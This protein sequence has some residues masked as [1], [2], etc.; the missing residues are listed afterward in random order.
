MHVN[1]TGLK[2]EAYYFPYNIEKRLVNAVQLKSKTD[3]EDALLQIEDDLDAHNI[4]SL[5]VAKDIVMQLSTSVLRII[6][7]HGKDLGSFVNEEKLYSN[8]KDADSREMLLRHLR[9]I[10]VKTA[11]FLDKKDEDRNKKIIEQAAM[12]IKEK[13]SSDISIADIADKVFISPSHLSRTFKQYMGKT[14]NDYINYIRIEKSKELL[15][16]ASNSIE[17][18]AESVG[19]NS[20]QNFLRNFKL[21]EGITPTE[22]KYKTIQ[23]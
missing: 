14:V 3:I 18:I 2:G 4:E 5:T 20:K 8:I 1:E 6:A 16:N 7:E 15:L 9:E 21:F 22:Y 23:K 19:Y 12:Y 17:K 11:E 10:S 13:Y